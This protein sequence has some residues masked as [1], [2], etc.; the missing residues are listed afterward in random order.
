MPF[1]EPASDALLGKTKVDDVLVN[2]VFHVK[3]PDLLGYCL[4]FRNTDG[5]DT[6]HS[7]LH[8][9]IQHTALYP[10][11]TQHLPCTTY[12]SDLSMSSFSLGAT[13]VTRDYAQLGDCLQDRVLPC[14]GA[15][16]DFL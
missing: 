13:A 2:T 4:L 14:L 12:L 3:N 9:G 10:I 11:D 1:K 5:W 8:F 7:F 16:D 15:S 6:V